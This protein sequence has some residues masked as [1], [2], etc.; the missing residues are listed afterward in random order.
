MKIGNL[1]FELAG[2]VIQFILHPTKNV[3]G[4]QIFVSNLNKYWGQFKINNKKADCKVFVKEFGY[5]IFRDKN[6]YYLNKYRKL[7][8][9]YEL[10][11]S[12]SALDI[13]LVLRD[14]FLERQKHDS[15]ILHASAVVDSNGIT[16]V[17]NAKSGG[18]KSTIAKNLEK[19]GY[20]IIADDSV[21]LR[22]INDSWIIYSTPFLEKTKYPVKKHSSKIMLFRIHKSIKCQ[23][24]TMSG[25]FVGI[26]NITDSLWTLN[27]N[28]DKTTL[29]NIMDLSS[30]IRMHD[31][32]VNLEP[33]EIQ[34][35]LEKCIN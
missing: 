30:K 35:E 22:K 24:K 31:L 20:N 6:N 14:I 5:K 7:G 4:Q 25:Q 33:R 9:R 13:D 26:K 17:F 19:I 11:Y 28:I 16:Y 2:L 10:A 8:N 3:V 15:L 29:S 12:T 34:K 23:S 21:I 27:S 1:Y 18:G 32:F